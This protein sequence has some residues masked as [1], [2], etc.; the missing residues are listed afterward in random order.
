MSIISNQDEFA[1]AQVLEFVITERSKTLSRREWKHRLAGFG[2]AI[3]ET[4]AGDVVQS[5]IGAKDICVLPAALS[6]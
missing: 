2:Y 6:A 5:L 3:R 1:Q 4:D